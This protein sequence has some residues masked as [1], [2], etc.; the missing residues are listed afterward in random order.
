MAKFV[1]T[2]RIHCIS[3]VIRKA[4]AERDPEPIFKTCERT[5]R[6]SSNIPDVNIDLLK[7]DGEDLMKWAVQLLQSNF[8]NVLFS[9]R[10]SK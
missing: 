7:N 4:M 10:Y 2:E 6:R 3:P 9:I 1:T 5:V 8:D